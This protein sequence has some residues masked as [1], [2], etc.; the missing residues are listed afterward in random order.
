MGIKKSAFVINSDI[1][2]T[3]NILD[4]FGKWFLGPVSHNNTLELVIV[5]VVFP[6]IFN[7]IQ[8]WIQDN[9]LKGRRHYLE[10]SLL[11]QDDLYQPGKK[12][13]VSH[14]QDYTQL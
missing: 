9:I 1:G 4:S 12:N 11:S 2:F 10:T 3:K 6:L 8:F 13:T 14:P 5:M 7:I